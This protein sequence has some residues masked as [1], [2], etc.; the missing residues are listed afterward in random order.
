MLINNPRGILTGS[1]SDLEAF[2]RFIEEKKVDLKP[3]VDRVFLFDDAKA[4]FDYFESGSHV[5]KVVVKM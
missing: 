2:T 4:A 1:R 5:G 3:L